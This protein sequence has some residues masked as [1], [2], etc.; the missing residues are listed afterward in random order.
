[1]KRVNL[2][3]PVLALAFGLAL[4]APAVAAT[5]DIDAAHSSVNFQI[6]HLAISKVNGSFGEFSGSFDYVEGEAG[7]WS[8]E[9]TIQAASI[10]TGNEDRD[11]HL[12]NADFFDVEKYPTL[13]FKTTGAKDGKLMG[14]LTMVGVTRPVELELEYNGG[15]TD[16]WGNEK[17]SFTATGKI[18]R[19]DF[20]MTWNKALDAGGVVL[21]DDVKF[22]LEIAGAKRK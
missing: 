8:A 4:Y 7:K 19:K 10:D 9:A 20:G 12:R 15:T 18:S 5:Y 1:M 6:R 13:T 17:V 21:G 2:I 16:P 3:L 22:T 14:E 11:N